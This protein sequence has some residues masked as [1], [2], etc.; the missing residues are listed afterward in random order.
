MAGES[1]LTRQGYEKLSNDL[2]A[3][4]ARRQALAKDIQEAAEK[5]DLKENAEYH[6]AREEQQKVNQR[7]NE[8]EQKLRNSRIL[9]DLAGGEQGVIRIGS[10]VGLKHGQTGEEVAYTFVDAAD[11][12]FAKGRI[13]VRSPLAEGLLGHKEG[14]DVTVRLPAGP[15]PYKILKVSREI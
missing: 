1:Y 10:S 14:E 2:K 5:G 6:A 12:D 11:A 3:L 9:D 8:L 13:S 7:A 4:K 15:V